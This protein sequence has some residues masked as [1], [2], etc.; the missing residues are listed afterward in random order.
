MG[1]VNVG[2][3]VANESLVSSSLCSAVWSY[4][5]DGSA[6]V[7]AGLQTPTPWGPTELGGGG[8]TAS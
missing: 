1:E 7:S 8:K 5:K 3:C 4:R 2:V 6:G